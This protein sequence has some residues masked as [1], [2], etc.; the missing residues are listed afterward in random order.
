MIE[1]LFLA[2]WSQCAAA[3]VIS[4]PAALITPAPVFKRGETIAGYQSTGESDGTI[5]CKYFPWKSRTQK[6]S[7]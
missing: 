3:G 2:L 5:L 6:E 4:A 1:I 7:P